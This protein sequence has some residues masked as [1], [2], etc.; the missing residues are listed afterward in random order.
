MTNH[1]CWRKQ[2]VS[3]FYLRLVLSHSRK[4]SNNAPMCEALSIIICAVSPISS[5]STDKKLTLIAPLHSLRP[6][7]RENC[8]YGTMPYRRLQNAARCGDIKS[9]P[10]RRYPPCFTCA[11]A[12]RLQWY[13]SILGRGLQDVPTE[14]RRPGGQRINY[15]H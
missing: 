12:P 9:L 6:K 11:S 4:R 5:I 2:V 3:P 7:E 1:L 15:F 14:I 8:S 10:E 13:Y